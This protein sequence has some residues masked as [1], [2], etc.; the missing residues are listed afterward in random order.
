MGGAEMADP[1]A[2][3]LRS[4]LRTIFA[5]NT[6]PAALIREA[7]RFGHNGSSA[8]DILARLHA[9]PSFTPL[10]LDARGDAGFRRHGGADQ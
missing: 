5:S 2:G 6:P 10:R 9:P 4:K 7:P 8:R 3:G 1:L